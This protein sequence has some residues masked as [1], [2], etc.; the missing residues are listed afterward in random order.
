MKNIDSFCQ[1]YLQSNYVCLVI[2]CDADKEN[3]GRKI[4][5][6]EST[7]LFCSGDWKRFVSLFVLPKLHLIESNL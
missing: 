2:L 5:P 3:F 1:T 7:W 4:V 6:N